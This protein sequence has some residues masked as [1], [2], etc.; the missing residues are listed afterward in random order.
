MKD[1]KD[2]KDLI[3]L[4]NL[5]ACTK[6]QKYYPIFH[7]LLGSDLTCKCQTSFNAL[8]QVEKFL[9]LIFI[10]A[11]YHIYYSNESIIESQFYS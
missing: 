10:H 1:M 7:A 4:Q 11:K 6:R 3:R 8:A 9:K 5:V 2:Q